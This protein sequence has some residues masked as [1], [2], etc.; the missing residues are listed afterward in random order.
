[1]HYLLT[2]IADRPVTL[3]LFRVVLTTFFWMAGLF[4]L[5]NFNVI[6][7]EMAAEKLPAPVA[8]AVLTIATQL[9]GSAL[10]ISDYRGLGWLGSGALVVFTLLTIP[11]GHAFWTFTEPKRTA[12]FHIALEHI[13]VVGGLLLAGLLSFK[14]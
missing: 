9:I 7:Q 4:G 6:V 5:F 2:T 10:L 8:F 13:T 14:K 3:V 12:E 1:M 11:I